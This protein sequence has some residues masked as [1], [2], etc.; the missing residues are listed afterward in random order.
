MTNDQPPRCMSY[1]KEHNWFSIDRSK[2]SVICS[3]PTPIA[4]PCGTPHFGDP[5]ALGPPRPIT[6]VALDHQ[7]I[8]SFLIKI[9]PNPVSLQWKFH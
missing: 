1:L 2:A 5:P 4:T 6:A 8:Q 3:P 7:W 9:Q